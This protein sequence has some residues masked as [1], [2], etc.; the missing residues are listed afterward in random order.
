MSMNLLKKVAFVT[1][2][3]SGIGLAVAR[4]V[5]QRGARVAI[6]DI[7]GDAL[8]EAVRG[9]ESLGV[10]GI[11]IRLD[12]RDRGAVYRAA[13]QVEEAF[14]R[15]DLVFNNAGIGDAGTPLDQVS[16]EFFDWIVHVNLFGVMNVLKAFVPKLKKHGQGGH[17]VNTSSMAGLVLMPGWNQ[18]LYS[19]TKM[20]VLALSLDLREALQPH[21]IGVSALCP[22]LVQTNIAK[23]AIALRP[24]GLQDEV[25][26]FPEA[27]TQ[28]G[29]PADALAQIALDGIEQDSPIIVT[30]P[31]FWPA[32][33]QF[34]AR[35]RSA[36]E[37]GPA[38]GLGE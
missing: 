11:G 31:E 8:A 4:A 25:H 9:I 10:E 3:A 22:G 33:E 32:V 5:A 26:A 30:H 23:N 17:I 1:G 21:R 2:G 34:H 38:R 7:Q 19:A 13:E 15:V 28:G 35:I 36:F 37:P 29:M 14:G 24:A 18:G 12:V 6:A 20:A 16:D 27:L